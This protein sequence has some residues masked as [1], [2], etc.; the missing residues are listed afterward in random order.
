MDKQLKT[1][2]KKINLFTNSE[3]NKLYSIFLEL[4]SR[5]EKKNS[6]LDKKEETVVKNSN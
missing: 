1:G 4:H 5:Q 6:N 2:V 3:K